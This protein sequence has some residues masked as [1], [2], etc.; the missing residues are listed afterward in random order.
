MKTNDYLLIAATGGYSYLFFEQNAGINFLFFNLL[1]AGIYLFKNKQLLKQI[2]WLWSLVLCLVSSSG[3]ILTSSSLA[4]I[5][6][7]T[8]LLILS[9]LSVNVKTSSIFSWLF[10]IYSMMSGMIW[11]I[12]DLIR[13]TEKKPEVQV[14]TKPTPADHV[15]I[16]GEVSS[17]SQ[18]HEEVNEIVTTESF[19]DPGKTEVSAVANK[20]KGYR[21]LLVGVVILL[22]LIFFALYKQAN[23]LF[24]EN[25]KWINLDFISFAWIAFTIGGFFVAYPLLYHRSIPVIETWENNLQLNSSVIK[26]T[27]NK[28]REIEIF[29]GMLLFSVLNFML[30]ILNYG[31][32]STLWFNAALPKG[33]NHSDFVHNG[34]GI[35]IL[36]ILIAMG[37]IMY[38]YNKNFSDYKFNSFLKI[39]I[40]L[41]ILQNITMLFSTSIRNGIYIHDFNLTYKRIGVYVWLCLAA[42]GLAVTFVKV[43]LNKSNWFLV[44]TNFG[45]WFTV[46]S[47]TSLLNWDVLITQYNIKNKP[48]AD[49][50]FYYL[51]SLSDSNIPEL[52]EVTKN[53]EF[54][55]INHN[56]KYYTASW[57]DD[58]NL[59]YTE[60]LEIKIRHYFKDYKKTWQSWDLRDE[61]VTESI[62]NFK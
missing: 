48:L 33:V 60:K 58:Y 41:W 8:S 30:V 49:V 39:L 9:G 32:I 52:M 4:I 14:Y 57:F 34:V 12:I 28:K 31:D 3:I 59:S 7:F 19:T 15:S 21:I 42:A 35:I 18:R 45:I 25:T 1:M 17:E 55:N 24:A 36:S 11:M 16:V 38:L 6:N 40:Y 23:P 37:L 51:F 56:L 43:L 61:R 62:Y 5:A 53:P 54:K 46:L 10:A 2:K 47:F 44:K 50:D 27:S 20:Y 13:R 29:A 22:C 26:G